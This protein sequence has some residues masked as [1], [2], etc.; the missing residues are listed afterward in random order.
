[1]A[2]TGHGTRGKSLDAESASWEQKMDNY[3]PEKPFHLYSAPSAGVSDGNRGGEIRR[4]SYASLDEAKHAIRDLKQG[5]SASHITYGPTE[6]VV[7]PA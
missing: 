6:T 2:W 7:W 1:M 3:D 5:Y 4:T